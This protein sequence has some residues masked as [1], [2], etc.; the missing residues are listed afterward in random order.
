MP[1]ALALGDG[2]GHCRSRATCSNT[3]PPIHQTNARYGTWTLNHASFA[4]RSLVS[5]FLF[6]PKS[7]G[8][9]EKVRDAGLH[10]ASGNLM[11]TPRLRL[12]KTAEATKAQSLSPHHPFLRPNLRPSALAVHTQINKINV[13]DLNHDSKRDASTHNRKPLEEQR[14]KERKRA[15]SPHRHAANACHFVKQSKKGAWRYQP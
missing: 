10:T 3:R 6:P 12:A 15:K 13:H 4:N 5:G 2:C 9:P 14:K 1:L 11:K 7:E 8:H